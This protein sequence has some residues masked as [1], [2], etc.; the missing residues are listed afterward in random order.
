MHK[1]L[2]DLDLL[3]LV[4]VFDDLEGRRT[5]VGWTPDDAVLKAAVERRILEIIAAEPDEEMRQT[6]ARLRCDVEVN[7]RSQEEM[8]PA[9]L[10]S[11]GVGGGVVESAASWP[12]GT[13][14][15]VQIRSA[16]SEERG[17]HVRGM[18][19]WHEEGPIPGL[20]VSFAE[21]PSP[22][23]ERRLQRF[24]REVLRQRVSA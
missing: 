16:A 14:V 1:E 15:H 24:V 18:I 12:I 4:E 10:R 5:P 9:R 11:V 2:D 6:S 7:L 8:V 22:A 21:Q 13:H 20:G 3:G 17:L 23:H 19:A